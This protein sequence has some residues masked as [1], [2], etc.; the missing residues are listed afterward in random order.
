V[1]VANSTNGNIN[2]KTD[3]VTQNSA[4][5]SGVVAT[6]TGSGSVTVQTDG[7]VNNTAGGPTGNAGINANGNGA[8]TGAVTVMAN[9]AV[10]NFAN[11]IIAGNAAT[12]GP[13]FVTANSGIT[14]LAGS[15]VIATGTT[16]QVTVDTTGGLAQA[17]GG[18]VIIANSTSGNVLVK[19]DAV[20]QNSLGFN[21]IIAN[22]S[23]TGSVTVETNGPVTGAG[24]AATGT[25]IVANN[26][27]ST[28]GA[29]V[30]ASGAVSGFAN[31]ID[32]GNAN[33]TGAVSVTATA[34]VNSLNGFGV[35]AQG[36]TGP[37]MVDTVGGAVVSNNG[38]G[39]IGKSST[40][41]LTIVTAG[42][43]ATNG[44]GINATSTTGGI[45]LISTGAVSSTNMT[46]II[47][48]QTGAG[49]GGNVLVLPQSTVS[50]TNG[51][52]ATAVST[53]NLEVTVS[54]NVT[55]TAGNGINSTVAA[56]TANINVNNPGTTVL[57]TSAG[58][59]GVVAATGNGGTTN[60]NVTTSTTVTDA[61]GRGITT[62]ATGSGVTN[63]TSTGT[64]V[65]AGTSTDAVISIGNQTG[66][67]TINNLGPGLIANHATAALASNSAA[68]II[69]TTPGATGANNIN[70]SG[71]VIGTVSLGAGVNTFT[72]MAGGQWVVTD[73]VGQA[74]A[75]GA[76]S[77]NSLIND[78]NGV[79]F[80]GSKSA[81]SVTN[82][83]GL[84]NLSNAGVFYAGNSTTSITNVNPNAGTTQTVVNTGLLAVNGTLNFANLGTQAAGST[85]TNGSATSVGVIDMSQYGPATAR[86]GTV[87]PASTHHVGDLVTLGTTSATGTSDLNYH[88]TFGPAYN[89]V[90]VAGQSFLNVDTNIGGPGSASDRL[91]ISGTASGKTGIGV[92]DTS[93]STGSLNLTGITLVAVNGASKNAFFLDGQFNPANQVP[94][95]PNY[96]LFLPNFGPM[97]AIQKGFFIYPLLQ[98]GFTGQ[99]GSAQG[100]R[101]ALFGLPSGEAFQL[102]IV[103]TAA[104]NI[105][106]Q[107]V[108]G[109]LDRQDE[110][111]NWMRRNQEILA[112][113]AGS[114][115]DMPPP[116][117]A[118]LAFWESTGPGVW[119]K[120]I[121]SFTNR[122]ASRGWGDILPAAAVLGNVDLSYHQGIGALIGGVD[123][124][125]AQLFSPFDALVLGLMGGYE[126]SDVHF[127]QS[128]TSFQFTGG[129]AGVSASYLWGGWFADGLFKADLLDVNMN[130]PAQ[131][132]F[133][134]SGATVQA[135]NVGGLG[136]FGYRW[137]WRWGL[138][139][140][141]LEPIATLSYV[142]TH[143]GNFNTPAMTARF[144]DGEA[145]RG[146][147]G[148]RVGDIWVSTP[149]W[150]VD[151]SVTG[152]FWDQFSTKNG[153]I[154]S[155][156]ESLLLTDIYSKTFGEVIAQLNITSKGS[157]WSA[158]MNTGVQFSND[159]TSYTGKG[160]AR[161]QW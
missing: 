112:A 149:T 68:A 135:T 44:N 128:P 94:G 155:T 152:K 40:G 101:Y 65:G 39:V 108:L 91:V 74:G 42:V 86:D 99:G 78:Q 103:T 46:G 61:L 146:A 34:G 124:G 110:I 70:N 47:A 156:A 19:T 45:T 93:S 17:T 59:S 144:K 150:E 145:F 105:W 84:A 123:F 117:K 22:A 71:T 25:G 29:T 81:G 48:V 82:F 147:L 67:V 158:Y 35:R 69:T 98:D 41:A 137:D 80:A 160:G 143:I 1:I 16:K 139:A 140:L 161:Y 133:G 136:N 102:P 120:A 97:G 26:T 37:V 6:A 8:G 148:L 21:G 142:S 77:N 12:A 57:G 109:W 14:A 54:H 18:D 154:L 157:G 151:T 27:T 129:T 38:D 90:G 83:S 53:N 72:N 115:A 60:I 64:I 127:R 75:F 58:N 5:F 15:A 85:F 10:T 131:Q 73:G 52:I 89:Y 130:F 20:T 11:G 119:M 50:G 31:G 153:V 7:V 92:W 23:T 134:F 104:Q 4:S 43:N 33:A 159:V 63:I 132:I 55:G 116:A 30:I 56:G 122:D 36:T 114:G 113:A 125:R 88:Y 28:G 66:A 141:Y 96:D 24:F 49:P 121:G 79:I 2:V 138:G 87:F 100:S 95:T 9:G 76:G 51:I 106:E 32:A 13:V 62:T 111:R 107:T 3:G 118:P 126:Y